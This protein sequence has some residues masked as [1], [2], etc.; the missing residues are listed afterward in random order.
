MANTLRRR[1]HSAFVA[2]FMFL[3]IL[4][5]LGTGTSIQAQESVE[6]QVESLLQSMTLEQRVGQMFMVSVYGVGLNDAAKAF[7]AEMMP[8]ASAFFSYNGTSPREINYSV[9]QWQ[10]TATSTGAKI[11][12]LIGI[13]HE[14]GSVTRLTSGVTLLP[15]GAALGAMP[16]DDAK[17]VGSIAGQELSAMGIQIN[18]AP[19]VDV[20]TLPGA[21]V[22]RRTF[23]NKSE[24][25]A[26]AGA[27]YIEGLHKAGVIGALKHFPGHGPAGDSH[28]LLPVVNSP[29][30][31][32]QAVELPPFKAGIDVG[33]EIVM[34]GH[35][36]YPA[37]DP[38]PNLPSSLS[39]VIIGDVL[40][41][42]LGFEGIVMTDG[43]DMAAISE[44]FDRPLSAVMAV[45][46]GNDWITTGPHI[47][48][49]QQLA[50]K[51][52]VIDAVNHG[53]ITEE[54][55]NESVRRILLLKAK[56]N[57]LNWTPLDPGTVEQRVQMEEHQSIVDQ[58]YLNTV[59]VAQDKQGLLPLRP[60]AKKSYLY[61]PRR[62]STGSACL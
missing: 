28:T 56:H 62:I 45:K 55:I 2:L 40:R 11:P 15:W 22:E 54:R 19:V 41:K 57:L 48:M 61:L 3:M 60:G 23:S 49:P 4:N 59:T 7:L 44:H 21:F 34:M 8:G 50:M 42:Q 9:N 18:F 36:Y 1:V 30:D 33:V 38:T 6:Q 25:V 26:K 46:A 14:G 27:A 39:P 24:I 31:Q 5:L 35:L 29:L 17:T 10:A 47:P 16:T 37:L 52:A 20:R 12:L 58:I 13:D 51:K 32:I 43:M 53:E